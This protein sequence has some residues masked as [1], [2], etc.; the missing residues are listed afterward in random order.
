MLSKHFVKWAGL[1]AALAVSAV[2][3][4]ADAFCRT[5]TLGLEKGCTIG[6]E[7]CCTRGKPLFWRN[8]CVGYSL[9]RDASHKVALADATEG[10]TRAFTKWTG[11]ACPTDGTGPSR[12]S[13][14]VRDLGPVTCGS[15]TY[16]KE[17]PNQNT[18]VF[19]DDRWNHD[20]SSNTL[21]LTTVVFDPATGEIYDADMEINTAQQDMTLRDPVPADGYD[22]DSVVTH[23]TGHFL[24]LAHS[25]DKH[26]TMFAH[27]NPG[28]TAMRNLTADDVAGICAVYLPNGDRVLEEGATMSQLACDPTPRHGYTTDCPEPTQ[29]TCSVSSVPLEGPG[30]S[31]P[32]QRMG[33]LGAVGLFG[34]MGWA[35]RK[36]AKR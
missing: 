2:A 18:I 8:A 24:G 33:V 4:R 36:S 31:D 3:S 1:A 11:T 5:S 26:A 20:D 13:I 32:W 28:S 19:R 34:I 15:V 16:N 7:E 23:E 27:Y 30:E 21:G 25:T 10:I 22:F 17:G 35:R 29:T 14:D 9:Q 6:G 12:V